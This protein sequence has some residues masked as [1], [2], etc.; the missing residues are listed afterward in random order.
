MKGEPIVFPEAGARVADY[1]TLILE[2]PWIDGSAGVNEE[3]LQKLGYI[4]GGTEKPA[5]DRA[6]AP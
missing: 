5:K 2:L 3:Q 6:P 4:D 1:D